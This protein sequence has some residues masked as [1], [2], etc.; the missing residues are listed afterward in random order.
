MNL[1][2]PKNKTKTK[3][4]SREMKIKGEKREVWLHSF[5]F[6]TANLFQSI[7]EMVRA[8]SP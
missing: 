1:K 7:G 2:K 6:L 5:A 8:L 4:N 3:Q